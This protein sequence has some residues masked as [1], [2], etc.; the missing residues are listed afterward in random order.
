VRRR[1]TAFLLAALGLA[2]MAGDLLDLET[3][4]GLAAAANASPAPRVFGTVRGHE[5]FSAGF[6]LEW[7][8]ADGTRHSLDLGPRAYARLR[9]PYNRRN[10]YGAALSYGPVLQDDARGRGLLEPVARHAVCG[11]AAALRE[12]SGE[13]GVV[14]RA[15]VSYRPAAGPGHRLDVVCP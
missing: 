13:T 5:T 10:A 2:Q 14:R 6:T 7:V 8:V 12:L 11:K 1:L 4:R 15:Q 3:L 9:G